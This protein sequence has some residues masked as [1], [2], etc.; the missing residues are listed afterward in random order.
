MSDRPS[1]EHIEQ[2]P[3]VLGGKPRLRGKRIAVIHLKEMHIDAGLS[4]E[5]I[6][7]DLP[8]T[9]AEVHA[10]LAYY[11]DHRSEIDAREAATKAEVDRLLR[12]R[13]GMEILE[14]YPERETG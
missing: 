5:E 9:P 4:V 8:V 6:C 1:I 7:R 12:E 13:G 3:G 14:K 11:H 2:T 10:A